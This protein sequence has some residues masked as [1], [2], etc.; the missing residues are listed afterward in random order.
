MQQMRLMVGHGTSRVVVGCQATRSA[1]SEAC[2]S[3]CFLVVVAVI[4]QLLVSW[5]VEKAPG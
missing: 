4:Q 2:D 1:C 5:H 3:L